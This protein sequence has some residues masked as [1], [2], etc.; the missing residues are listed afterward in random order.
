MNRTRTR[1]LLLA[2][3]L[4]AVAT[5]GGVILRP[6]APVAAQTSPNYNLEWHVI[7]GGGQA[8]SSASY[9][10]NGTV[11]QAVTSPHPPQPQ[12]QA[13]AHFV[14]SQ[15]YWFGDG[16]TIRWPAYLPL[17]TRNHP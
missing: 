9:R 4:L 7:G 14:I 3:G 2:A 15:G 13:S 11:G 10:V 5:I 8:V 17:V 12:Y 6:T 16:I 1:W